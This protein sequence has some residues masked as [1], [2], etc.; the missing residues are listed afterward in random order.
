MSTMFPS[1]KV[2][3]NNVCLALE[4]KSLCDE[5]KRVGLG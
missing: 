3:L 5:V 2:I 4:I 1:E